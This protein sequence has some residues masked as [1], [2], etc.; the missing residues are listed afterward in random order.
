M[1]DFNIPFDTTT[2]VFFGE[3]EEPIVEFYSRETGKHLSTWAKPYELEITK[4][5]DGVLSVTVSRSSTKM[6]I[7]SNQTPG[8]V[9]T[10]DSKESSKKAT[11]YHGDVLTI[12]GSADIGFK[13]PILSLDKTTVDGKVTA[14]ATRG[15]P[16]PYTLTVYAPPT[17]VKSITVKRSSSPYQGATFGD[18]AILATTNLTS[19]TKTATIYYGDV[20]TVTAV[21]DTGYKDPEISEPSITVGAAEVTVGNSASYTC[22]VSNGGLKTYTLTITNSSYGTVEKGT[23]TLS[24][25]ATITH[26]DSLTISPTAVAGYTTT[27][28]SSTGTI[29]NNTLSVD[30]NET[31]EFTRTAHTYSVKF[32]GN[33]ATSG[34]VANQSFTYGTAQNLNSNTFERV[35]TITYN[36]NYD[37]ATNSS[38]T[39][40]STFNGWATSASGEKVYNNGQSVWDLTA[41]NNGTVELFA[42]WTLGTTT[43]PVPIRTGYDFKGWATSETETSGSTGSY[44]PGSDVILYA[45]WERKAYKLY[46][47]KRHTNTNYPSLYCQY[48]ITRNGEEIVNRPSTEGTIDIYYGDELTIYNLYDISSSYYNSTDFVYLAH[49]SSGKVGKKAFG[50]TTITVVGDVAAV[51]GYNSSDSDYGRYAIAHSAITIADPTSYKLYY[52]ARTAS[53]ASTDNP[54][55]KV[56]RTSSPV[57]GAATGVLVEDP[58]AQSTATIYE[59]DVLNIYFALTSADVYSQGVNS[60]SLAPIDGASFHEEDLVT[61]ITVTGDIAVRLRN[62]SN[63]AYHNSLTYYKEGGVVDVTSYLL[64]YPARMA[65]HISYSYPAY[66]IERTSSPKA[67]ASTG[68]L[69]EQPIDQGTTTIYDGDV[70][71]IYYKT[72]S[73]GSYYQSYFYAGLAPMYGLSFYQEDLVTDI[74]VNRDVAVCI[75]ETEYHRSLTYYEEEEEVTCPACGETGYHYCSACGEYHYADE[76]CPE[77]E[78]T[79]PECGGTGYHYCTYCYEYHYAEDGCPD[80]AFGVCSVCG[81][82]KP[83]VDFES[84]KG[85]GTICS[86][87]FENG[88][89]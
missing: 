19:G 57:P 77:P 73:S 61:T 2:Q 64:Y 16:N 42:N 10:N 79:C 6:S 7:V 35:H 15:A 44:T 32:N 37:G 4:M 48:K 8:A 82:R 78:V 52:P 71:K 69:I 31:I 66:K 43:L 89:V 27:A 41:T 38:E 59:G 88:Y 84:D 23:T 1:A 36:Q 87:C 74:T 65:S 85:D 63:F 40:V 17:G 14:T 58:S 49:V 56:E 51:V 12:A 11:V 81:E 68:V 5:P 9:L 60:A 25:G 55:F 76:D 46:Y 26:F 67:G 72:S 70:L 62:G 3:K 18:D 47:P 45:V 28:S 39:V 75:N 30:G 50:S 54:R 53:T 86:D 83:L 33:G 80:S 29:S 21:A 34:S 13:P 20:L 24:N 22:N